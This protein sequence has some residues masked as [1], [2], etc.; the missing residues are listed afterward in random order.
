MFTWKI[1]SFEWFKHPL[2]CL[3]YGS[4]LFHPDR[5]YV[6][7]GTYGMYRHGRCYMALKNHKIIW[8]VEYGF[9]DIKQCRLRWDATHLGLNCL[10]KSQCKTHCI[11]ILVDCRNILW[12]KMALMHKLWLIW[13]I[14]FHLTWLFRMITTCELFERNRKIRIWI[15]YT[16]IWR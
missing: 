12:Y 13:R 15:K 1:R 2:F 8:L 4:P 3:N 10:P 11:L 7:D 9:Y 5:M 14:L 16:M 6:Q